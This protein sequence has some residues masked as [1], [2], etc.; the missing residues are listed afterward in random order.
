MHALHIIVWSR[1]LGL[2]IV[3][4]ITIGMPNLSCVLQFIRNDIKKHYQW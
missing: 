1:Q 2:D 3:N 4:G